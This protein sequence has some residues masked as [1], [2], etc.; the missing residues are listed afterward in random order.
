MSGAEDLVP[1]ADDAHGRVRYRPRTEG[2]FAR[3]E[4]V[5]DDT[6]DYW[7]VRSRDGLLTRYGTPRPTD[8]D[9][10]WRDPAVT[11]DR[12]S[13]G[14]GR[15]FAWRITETTDA[16]GN[17]VRYSYARDHGDE[18][19][20]AWD[21]PIVSRIEYADYGDRADPSFL[22]RVD[23]ELRAAPGPVLRLPG[24]V[25]GPNHAAVPRRSGCPRTPP[26]ASR[27]RCAS[28]ASATSRRRSTAPRCSP[29]SSVVGVDDQSGPPRS[30]PLPPLTFGYTAFEPQRRRFGPVTGAGLPTRPLGD[31]TMAMVDLRGRGLPD[32][33][34]LGA[35]ARY[36]RN[37]GGGRFELPRAIPEAPPQRLGE[38]GVQFI[39]A[40]GDGRADLL[41]KSASQAGY[42]PMTFAGGWSR[43]SFQP[44]R[45]APTVGL[46]DPRVK[47]VD[48]DG[49][50]LTDVLRSGS[51]LECWF[52]DADP[53]RAWQRTAVTNGP[54][55]GID[56]ADPHVRLADMTGDGLQDIVLLRSGNIAYWPNLGHGRFGAPVQMRRAPRLPD[57]H[58]PR[59]LLLGDVDGDGVA[60]LI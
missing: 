14:R 9:P 38:P 45:Q 58:D 17:L 20:H 5:R 10:D 8:A 24:R 42:F 31:P 19:G 55:A 53:R 28:T 35:T 34:E 13:G 27:V 12:A 25:R 23:F 48:L 29:A 37:L 59:R 39:D 46:D 2:L 33:V 22:V 32:I 43:R 60:D 57:G 56:L 1:V 47:L 41:V 7:E 26:T 6:S 30:E 21:Q 18:P 50:G 11:D 51:P 40:D 44:Y 54:A 52:N 36:W 15:V 4:H 16:V 49:D 3:I